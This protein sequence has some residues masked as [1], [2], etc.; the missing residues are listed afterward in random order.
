LFVVRVPG[1]PLRDDL[2]LVSFSVDPDWDTPKVLTEYAH[3]FG[4]DRSHWLFSNRRQEADL[5]P[6]Q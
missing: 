5:S 1:L 6:G 2:R 3:T 4:A